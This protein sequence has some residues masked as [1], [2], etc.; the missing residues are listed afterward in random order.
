MCPS[1]TEGYFSFFCLE[2]EKKTL[3]GERVERATAAFLLRLMMTSLVA[4]NGRA[5]VSRKRL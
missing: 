5:A 4:T 3:R 1:R 2:K